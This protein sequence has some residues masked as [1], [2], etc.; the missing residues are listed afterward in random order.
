MSQTH[1]DQHKIAIILDT[2]AFVAGYDPFSLNEKQ[3][4]V[5][6]VEQEIRRK[7]TVKIRLETALES[8]RV[9]IM[10]PSIEC[11]KRVKQKSGIIGDSFNLSETDIEL[12]ALSLQLKD[13]GF[14]PRLV[15]DD[16]SI[17]N[18]ATK[19]GIEFTALA[20]FGI[21]HLIE[22]KRYCPACHQEYRSDYKLK[23]CR[24]CGTELKRKPSKFIKR[25]KNQ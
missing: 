15:T 13:G 12:L 5:P 8:G 21:K 2:S 10:A 18:V 11:I 6:L 9:T 7:S 20:T 3:V 16:Y 4:T 23:E 19:F 22:W 14:L 25:L 17:Q 24:V 1:D